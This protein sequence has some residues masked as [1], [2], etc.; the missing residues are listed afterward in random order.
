MTKLTPIKC[1]VCEKIGYLEEE[2]FYTVIIQG[3]SEWLVD[4]KEQFDVC[5][6][7]KDKILI[8]INKLTQESVRK[9]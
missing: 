1:D 6:E 4:R 3:Q 5:S 8:Y 9:K 7:C 2:S